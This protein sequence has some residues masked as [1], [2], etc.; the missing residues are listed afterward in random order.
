MAD[1]NKIDVRLD[2]DHLPAMLVV[3]LSTAPGNLA[4]HYF[5]HKDF[6]LVLLWNE[7]SVSLSDAVVVK[8]LPPMSV[9]DFVMGWIKQTKPEDFST[10]DGWDKK[11]DDS[12]VS[13][14]KGFRMYNED[15]GHVAGSFY[16][17]VA[18]KPVYMW[19]GK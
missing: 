17:I 6:G 11:Y 19:S 9:D 4:T 5:I 13:N 8:P 16:G 12:D 10:Q 18:I 3:A 1:N 7:D 2:I 14:R 15:W